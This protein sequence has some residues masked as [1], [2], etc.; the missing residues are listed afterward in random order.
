MGT[1]SWRIPFRTSS[2]DL[3]QD[4][5]Y[6]NEKGRCN[7][8]KPP[9]TRAATSEGTL[10]VGRGRSASPYPLNTLPQGKWRL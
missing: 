6:R 5:N 8:K 7:K 1:I 9:L 10:R 3:E 4:S 2:E